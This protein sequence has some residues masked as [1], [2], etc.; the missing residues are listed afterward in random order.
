LVG[1]GLGVVA[2]PAS[3]AGALQVKA[4]DVTITVGGGPAPTTISITNPTGTQVTNVGVQIVLPLS[5]YQVQPASTPSGCTTNGNEVDCTIATLA[6]GDTWSRVLQIKPPAQSSIASGDQKSDTAQ[7]QL[8]SGESASFNVTLKGAAAPP[9]PTTPTVVPQVTGSVK[10]RSTGTPV[11][12]AQVTMQDDSRHTYT[13]GTDKNGNFQFASSQSN[14]ISPGTL[15]FVVTKDGYDQKNVTQNANAGQ[16]VT[17]AIVLAATASSASAAPSDTS[18]ASASSTDSAAAVANPA[19]NATSGGGGG[20]SS[21][22]FIVIG[23]ILVLL[24]IGAIALILWRRKAD[25][26]QPEDDEPASPRRG[27]TPVPASRGAYRGAPADATSVV[28]GGGYSDPTMVS[29]NPLADAPTMMHRPLA[30]EYPDPYGAPDPRSGGGYG[31]QAPYQ[32]GGGYQGGQGGYGSPAGFGSPAGNPGYGEPTRYDPNPGGYGGQGGYDQGG[33]YQQQQRPASDPYASGHTSGGGY[34]GDY[35][36]SGYNS[37]GGG[38]DQGGGHHSAGGHQQ[39]AGGYG[40]GQGYQSSGQGYQPPSQG[41][42]QSTPDYPPAQG[43]QDYQRDQGYQQGYG[44]QRGGY[45]GDSGGGYGDG[46]EP[47]GGH[48]QRGGGH[49]QRGGYDNQQPDQRRSLDWLDD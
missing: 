16:N 34:G 24:G 28:R 2:S 41:G 21:S 22:M 8:S 47:R 43:G 39:P 19:A 37:G 44:D 29:R 12:D 42:Y 45:Q 26:E 13:T 48:Q 38:Y 18:A 10:D 27:P 6:A 25:R 30:D 7:V 3:A 14:P 35:G 1:G 4:N 33:G 5:Q 9:S 11:A 31:G 23:A 40:S 36:S 17:I 20:G 15:V 32:G 46:Y 49:Q